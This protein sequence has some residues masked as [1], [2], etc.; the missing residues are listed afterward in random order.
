[1]SSTTNRMVW[2]DAARGLAILLVVFGH[3]ERGLVSAGIAKGQS[4]AWFDYT[5]YTFHMPAFF[6]FAG[7]TAKGSLSRK[8]PKTF[9][10]EKL[11]TI[12]YPYFLWSLLQGG[13]MI[14]L[15]GSTNSK[16][17]VSGLLDICW[18]PI[19]QFWFLYALFIYQIFGS[20]LY[21][22]RK[23]LS[24]VAL[25]SFASSE[26]IEPTSFGS[27][28]LHNF[29]FYSLGFVEFPPL[30]ALLRRHL[31]LAICGIALMFTLCTA[32]SGNLDHLDPVSIFA[33][34]STFFGIL[35]L[36]ALGLWENAKY[37]DLLSVLGAASM[38]IY[39][40]HIFFAA[41]SRIAL[42]KLHCCPNLPIVYLVVCSLVGTAAPLIIHRLIENSW[43]LPA[44]GLG[45]FRSKKLGLSKA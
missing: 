17:S 16:E 27:T 23:I 44:L 7:L 30:L 35:F 38:T 1:M 31:S 8:E 40:L 3:V 6:L 36:V 5:I 45:S 21:K 37:T 28:I 22:R 25:L 9:R 42:D 43:L 18:H 34:P 13:V 32:F 10:V 12:V 39:I 19:G 15:S 2:L 11:K 41:G 4:W 20:L 26:V 29:I 33:T 14:A 24:L